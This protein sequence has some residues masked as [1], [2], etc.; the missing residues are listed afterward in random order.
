MPPQSYTPPPV[1]PTPAAS[2]DYASGLSPAAEA[3]PV[4]DRSR[5]VQPQAAAAD[6][7]F[8]APAPRRAR[9][10]WPL[11]LI[12][13]VLVA[14]GGAWLGRSL[15]GGYQRPEVAASG[16]DATAAASSTAG[17]SDTRPDWQRAYTDNF[18]SVAPVSLVV[19]S[20]ANVRNYPSTEDTQT[21]S[22]L[23]EGTMVSGR[24]V[25]GK[26]PTTRWLLLDSGGY[27]WD[28]NLA[29][30]SGPGSPITIALTNRDSS[31]G[32]EIDS[33]IDQASARARS[34]GKPG[35]IDSIGEGE[36]TYARVPNRRF[37]G[38]TVTGV[39]V[40]YEA[41]SIVFREAPE[42]VRRAFRDAGV[43]VDSNGNIPLSEDAVESCTI[44]SSSGDG[45]QYGSTELNCGV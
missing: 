31:F 39:G 34:S 13:V 7:A 36:S 9:S 17:D 26:D 22:E 40:H 45:T 28:G 16:D 24:W 5:L 19:S 20:R 37:H 30:Q 2:Q 3:P 10:L 29:Q 1:T 21:T 6:T 12:A 25:R 27:V 44:G 8:D 15:F 35:M 32:R 43:R 38:L 11:L 4:F 42:A 41:T 23:A 18:A 33:Y 14:V